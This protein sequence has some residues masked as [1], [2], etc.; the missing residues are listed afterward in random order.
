MG[1]PVSE[2]AQERT[3]RATPKRLRDARQ[4]GQVPR[5]KELASATLL[6]GGTA[7]LLIL[8]PGLVIWLANIMEFFLSPEADLRRGS[9]M[10]SRHVID[11]MTGLAA[12]VGPFLMV[13]LLLALLSPLLLGG[14]NFTT[15]AL[16]PKWDRLDPLRG[17][18][19]LFSLQAL[20]ELGKTLGKFAVVAGI[21]VGLLWGLADRF[22]AIGVEPLQS[23]LAHA[24]SLIGGNFLILT[25]PLI[26]L[27]AV[28]V[29]WQLWQHQRQLRM[30]RQEI[31]DE[32]KETE[33]RPEV[34]GRIRRL[35]LEL[36]QRRMMEDV[37]SADVVITN[38]T[39][40][41]VALR[42]DSDVMAAP[43]MVAKGADLIALRIKAL[44]LH[45]GV[46]VVESPPLARAVYYTTE[47]GGSVASGLYVAVA[48]VLAF[49]FQ[50]RTQARTLSDPVVMDDLPIPDDMK[51]DR[52]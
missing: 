48:Q 6:L 28:D 9:G 31:R 23:A 21:V 24:G 34:K 41:A 39:H 22:L 5:S 37:P 19:R 44:A 49:V 18:A 40:F 43:V 14:W 52:P 12:N 45:S 8:G 15:T 3:E 30:S 17:F 1:V 35:Q 16:A 29:P 32:L 42:Y 26:I 38:P 36:S 50:L 10:S 25:T 46:P 51:R 4:K 47:I 33:G 11:L 13:M 27:A 20:V 2:T 7:S